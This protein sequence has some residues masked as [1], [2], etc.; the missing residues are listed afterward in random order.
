MKEKFQV[1]YS[2]ISSF[3][4]CPHSY[5]FQYEYRNPKTGNRVGVVN[6]YLSL[7]LSVHRAIEDLSDVPIKERVKISLKERFD[8][9]FSEYR[10]LKGGF[11]SQK[12]EDFFYKR[13]LEMMERVEKSSFLSRPS[14]SPPSKF[15]TTDIV[16]DE[17]KIIGALDW[18]EELPNGD[19]HI[20]DFK[21][22]NNKEKSDSLQLPIYALLA[23]R[24]LTGK[25]IKKMSYWYLQSDD[26]PVSQE[27]KKGSAYLDTL[28]EKAVAI[29]E[30]RENNDFSCRYPGR[31]FACSDYEKIF[32]GEA[33]LIS[34]ENG[35]D[36]FC[37]FKE[38]EVV[39]KIMEE[40]F[41][42]EREKKI[43]EMR[44]DCDMEDI[45]RQLRLS[46]KKSSL[47]VKEI[48]E[49]LLKNLHLQELKIVIKILQ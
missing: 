32:Q 11:I 35:R 41:L 46:E 21:T 2:A 36:N 25:K 4:R 20:I 16:E 26:N 47:I 5:Y 6:P 34:S 8:E 12:K 49:K 30:A 43:F 42:D 22:G 13:G 10:G 37:V 24:N 7:G 27:I 1:S 44:M 40:E 45:N 3:C 33:E 15:L 18:I 9:I 48:K 38:K 14:I 39:E 19:L 28:K 17:I 23:E 29:K 31:C